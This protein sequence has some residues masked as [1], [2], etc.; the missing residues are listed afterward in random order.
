M[1]IAIV[2]VKGLIGRELLSLLLE[3][4]MDPDS[5]FLFDREPGEVM[6]EEVCYPVEILTEENFP[7]INYTFFCTQADEAKKLIP[8]VRHKKSIV[9]DLSSAFNMHSHVPL[10]VPEIN[11]EKIERDQLLASPNCVTTLMSTVLFPLHKE[12]TIKR[13]TASTYQ[14]ASGGGDLLLDALLEGDESKSPSLVHNLYLHDSPLLESNYVE[15]ELQIIQEIRKILGEEIEVG[16]T[17]VRVPV[18]QAH[19]LA[20]HVECEK[21]M[22]A[23]K[24]LSLLSSAPGLCYT[25]D[26]NKLTPAYAAKKELIF[27]GRVKDD[28]FR[29][30]SV[31]LWVVGD[32]L[33]KGTALNALQIFQSLIAKEQEMELTN[34]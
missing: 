10:I 32:Q 3:D 21:E 4:G 24:A 8:F 17:C 30:N 5:L 31:H 1:Q 12:A 13:V 19:S 15:E 34:Q 20:L 11:Q 28:L 18:L 22:S 7:E 23:K 27:C 26:L 25:E 14:A 6:I 29:R 9:I 33:L 16:I 2:G